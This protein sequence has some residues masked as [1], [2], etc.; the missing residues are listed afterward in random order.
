[1]NALHI[2]WGT[3]VLPLDIAADLFNNL[4]P[5]IIELLIPEW[6][7]LTPRPPTETNHQGNQRLLLVINSSVGSERKIRTTEAAVQPESRGR[8]TRTFMVML[9]RN[10]SIQMSILGVILQSRENNYMMSEALE[11]YVLASAESAFEDPG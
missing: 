6:L 1:M 11:G 4:S 2:K 3:K 5:N 9:G 8:H 7:H 10:P